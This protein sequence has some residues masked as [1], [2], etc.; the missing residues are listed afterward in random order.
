MREQI[1]LLKYHPHFAA[2][3]GKMFVSRSPLLPGESTHTWH[4]DAV[5]LNL[6]ELW[7]LKTVQASQQG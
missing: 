7:L 2:Q 3:P 4:H 1:E 6:S 5:N